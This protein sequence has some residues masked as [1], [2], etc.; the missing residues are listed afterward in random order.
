M[1]V[2]EL[3]DRLVRDEGLDVLVEQGG[4]EDLPAPG[5][6]S[7]DRSA[8]LARKGSSSGLPE[9]PLNEPGIQARTRCE[10]VVVRPRHHTSQGETQEDVVGHV[11]RHVETGERIGVRAI[12][13]D[14][15][16]V[17]ERVLDR[18]GIVGD[19][20]AVRVLLRVHDAHADVSTPAPAFEVAH[21]VTA[22]GLLVDREILLRVVDTSCAGRGRDVELLEQDALDS[23][24]V[25]LP[26]LIERRGTADVLEEVPRRQAAGE[27][28][29]G[30]RHRLASRWDRVRRVEERIEE[31]AVGGRVEGQLA[32]VIGVLGA[33]LHAP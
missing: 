15:N 11:V 9:V 27:I 10:L 17:S 20:V 14:R 16:V 6:H 18:S 23:A 21:D 1:H 5:Y 25:N 4:A 3:R 8:W 2:E 24:P 33:E 29:R 22:V 32:I 30:A 26:V 31:A 19:Q 7:I 28:R 12:D 13:G